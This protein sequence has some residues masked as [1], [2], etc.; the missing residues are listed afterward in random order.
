MAGPTWRNEKERLITEECYKKF[1]PQEWFRGAQI[2]PDHPKKLGLTL[3][4]AVNYKPVFVMKE[5]AS[6]ADKYGI[7]LYLKEVDKDGNP[8]E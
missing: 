8:V 4:I 6:F 5:I 7:Q 3:E 1:G 2:Y